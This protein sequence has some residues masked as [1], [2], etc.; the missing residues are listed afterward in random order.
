[1]PKL[2]RLKRIDQEFQGSSEGSASETI[3]VNGSGAPVGASYLVLATDA[4][5]T[6]E[7][8]ASGGDGITLTDGGAKSTATFSIDLA[9]TSGLELSSSELLLGT[10]STLT[11]TTSNAVT[12]TSHTHAI[13]ASADP[14][15]AESLLKTTAS[16][17]L[18]LEDLI[19]TNQILVNETANA[20]QTNGLTVKTATAGDEMIALKYS[21]V[22]HS[23]TGET[24]ADTFGVLSPNGTNG[25]LIEGFSSS[26]AGFRMYANTTTDDTAKSTSAN[27]GIIFLHRK[28]DGGT[29]V[30]DVGA[31]ANVLAIGVGRGGGTPTIFLV[32]EDGDLYIDGDFFDIDDPDT[33]LI[34]GGS[35]SLA[36]QAGGVT[37]LDVVE[38]TT[39]YV[40]VTQG[41]LFVNETANANQ[42]KGITVNQGAIDGGDS[43]ILAF[44]DTQVGHGLTG[45]TETDT[46]GF[47]RMN[48]EAE[49]AAGGLRIVGLSESIIS[50]GGLNLYGYSDPPSDTD[51]N[52]HA[53]I[54]ILG[55][56]NTTPSGGSLGDSENLLLIGNASSTATKFLMKGNGDTFLFGNTLMINE[57][58]NANQ[59]VGLTINT[60]TASDEA[61]AIK[62]NN[63]AHGMTAIT[64]TN[65]AAVLTT[66]NDGGFDFRGYGETGFGILFT[67]YATS[68]STGT[69]TA[70]TGTIIVSGY[71]SSGTGS[72]TLADNENIMVLRNGTTTTAIFKANGRQYL[73]GGPLIRDNFTFMAYS[74]DTNTFTGTPHAV[75]WNTEWRKDSMYSHTA[76][77][78]TVTLEEGGDYIIEADVTCDNTDASN[79]IEVNAYIAKNGSKVTGSDAY[80]YHRFS[81]TGKTT[82]TTRA[83]VSASSNDTITVEA[84]E[85]AGSGAAVLV[86]GASRIKIQRI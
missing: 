68:P 22:A 35:D 54:E 56:K 38:S 13:T 39:D 19:V 17:L 85:S 67:A 80:S 44:K 74:T 11:A 52:T 2:E 3:V 42:E 66:G 20:E 57:T 72:T 49:G 65:T 15:A 4:G 29:G 7:R 64:E 10:P 40:N 59:T 82:L 43:E 69:A 23:M 84:L 32:D 75:T 34:F 46:F 47:F 51:S 8:V 77:S 27:A 48:G 14:G 76:A 1:M 12:A 30:G 79:R 62:Q 33:G 16:G 55:S 25:F 63:V 45:V 61:F 5:L 73:L 81:A 50:G 83:Y 31:D 18:T 6:N 36:I 78:A 86:S 26:Y 24:E 37:M 21:S 41:L 28:Y 71:K 60:G 70:A 58:S 9:T 53:T